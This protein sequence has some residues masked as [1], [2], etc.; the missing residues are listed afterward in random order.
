MFD[1]LFI[2]FVRSKIHGQS[3]NRLFREYNF[4]EINL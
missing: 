1:L 2:T 3:F 4:L